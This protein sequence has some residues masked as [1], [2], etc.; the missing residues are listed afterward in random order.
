MPDEADRTPL[1]PLP[2]GQRAD[3]A[4]PRFGV[5]PLPLPAVPGT[6]RLRITGG[7]R[8]GGRR[9]GNL[10]APGEIGPEDLALLPRREQV[11]DLHCVTTWTKRGLCWQGWSLRDLYEQLLVPRFRPREV[12][13]LV[14]YGLDG[15]RTTLD[16]ED[17]LADGV[18]VADALDGEPLSSLHG[19]PLRV[20]SPGQYAYKSLKHLSGIALRTERPRPLP[21]GLEHPRARVEREERHARLPAWLVR[22]PYRALVGPV[23]YLQ[24]RGLTSTQLSGQPTRLDQAMPE[25]EV[26]ELHHRWLDA[27]PDEVYAALLATTSREIRLL[28]PLMALR[29]LPAF[30]AGRGVAAERTL[31]VFDALLRSG[32]L[33]LAEDPGREIVFGVVGRFWKLAGRPDPGNAPLCSVADREGFLAFD[34]PGYA[35]AA[36]SFLVRPEGR[37]SRL[38]TE[39]RVA[40]TDTAASRSFRRYWRL[41]RPGSGAI[42]R[43]WLAAVRR[44]LAASADSGGSAKEA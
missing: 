38:V 39:T 28:G 40:G 43:S 42:R 41:I 11:S 3:E 34:R 35:K 13:F 2:P 21:L 23:A 22:L 33:R 36:M 7:R 14:L 29:Q 20:V 25:F 18:L 27:T 1:T 15:Y 12:R 30:L 26:S 4:F 24:H 10:D 8:T 9:T 19:A 5:R 44:R 37:G 16:L 31:P 17:A 32:F 6:P